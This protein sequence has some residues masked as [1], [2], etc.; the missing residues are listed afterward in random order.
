MSRSSSAEKTVRTSVILPE[1]AHQQV[2]ALAQANR[3][4]AAWV[5]RTA[6]HEFLSERQ[7]QLALPL[8]SVRMPSQ[9]SS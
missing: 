5:I 3:V 6:I 8:A 4:S 2:Q 7:G 9:T 1:S